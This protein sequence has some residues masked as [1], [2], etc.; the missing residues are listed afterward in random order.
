MSYIYLLTKYLKTSKNK[1]FGEFVELLNN[2]TLPPFTRYYLFYIYG[3]AVYNAPA[4]E[5]TS[6][7]AF[8]NIT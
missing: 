5:S 2:N 4:H 6:E 7:Y 8:I 3:F 1:T